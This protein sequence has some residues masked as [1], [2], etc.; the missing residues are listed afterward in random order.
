LSVAVGDTIHWQWSNG[1]HTTTSTSVPA[2]AATWNS[3]MNQTTTSFEYKVTVPGNYSY[4]CTPHG[5]M[6]MLGSFSAIGVGINTNELI[7][8]IRLFPN[9]AKDNATLE[10]NATRSAQAEIKIIDI[11]G[12][13]VAVEKHEILP[14]KNKLTVQKKKFLNFKK[15][16][17]TQSIKPS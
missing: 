17:S 9:P 4:K 1:S 7:T 2:G 12:K 10:V 15:N 8:S 16:N 13:V 3:N 5:G 6:G 11:L 14:G